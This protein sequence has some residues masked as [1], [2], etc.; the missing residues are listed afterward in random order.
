MDVMCI[1]VTTMATIR[2]KRGNVALA[3]IIRINAQR[4]RHRR[5]VAVRRVCVCLCAIVAVFV[6][7]YV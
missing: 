2:N 3:S 5:F 6:C 4:A 7:F 1:T